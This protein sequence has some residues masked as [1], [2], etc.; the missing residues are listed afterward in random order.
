LTSFI[1]LGCSKPE[2]VISARVALANQILADGRIEE[3][4]TMLEAL[5]RVHP[6][7]PAVLETLGF[8]YAQAGRHR[9]AGESFVRAA[10]L[11]ANS[12]TL[13]TLAAESFMKEGD[14]ARA[15]EQH[16]LYLAQFPGDYQSWQ[17]LGE[18]EERRADLLRAIE[19]YLEWFRIRPSGECA[20]RLATAFRRLNNAPQAR[21]W[22]ETTIRQGGE[23]ID[24][25][26]LGVLEL[27]SADFAAAE[28][29]VTQLDAHFPGTLDASPLAAVRG[30]IAAWKEAD[31]ALAQARAEQERL[32]EELAEARRR[33]QEELA[34]MR[35]ATINASQQPEPA[36]PAQTDPTDPGP[37]APV[38]A[39]FDGTAPATESVPPENTA[40]ATPEVPQRPAPVSAN[41]ALTAAWERREAGQID[42]A[43]EIL[44]RALGQDDNQV[45]VWSELADCYVSQEEY[46]PAEA[47]ILEARRRAPESIEIETAFLNIVRGSQPREVYFARVEEARRKFPSNA[48]LAYVLARELAENG[49]DPTRAIVA[50][51][52]FLLLADPADPRRAEASDFLARMRQR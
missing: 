45:D 30:R 22:F 25:A 8:A 24:D 40:P 2:E 41:P 29:T 23:N 33:Q 31:A 3:A 32:T 12:A 14:F 38:V 27:E 16:R 50:Y 37:V 42:K 34:R 13:R 7:Q 48:S 49:G 10:G 18:I 6:D 36:Q 52:D 15:A 26:L 19:A 51:D 47:C 9:S 5:D 21:Q 35:E 1:L 44:W 17:K 20:F 28:R 4:T 11:D 46:G 43:V 39:S